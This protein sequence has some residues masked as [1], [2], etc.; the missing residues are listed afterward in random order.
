M[1]LRERARCR[2]APQVSVR[3]ERFGGL[4]Y[5]HDDRTL[6]FL[7]SRPLVDLLLGLDGTRTLAEAL[8][9]LAAE[10]GLG[11]GELQTI[12]EALGRLEERGM[13]REL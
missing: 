3:P 9:E 6:L 4:L 2:L 8:S 13:I 12:K 5:R 7:R 1:S 11:E 10:R